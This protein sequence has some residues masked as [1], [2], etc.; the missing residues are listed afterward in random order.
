MMESTLNSVRARLQEATS[1]LPYLP[2]AFRLLWEASRNWSVAWMLLLIVQGVLPGAMVYLARAVVDS[3]VAAL[4]GGAA[5]QEARQTL[6]LAAALGG[7]ML[8]SELIRAALA[9]IRAVQSERVQDFVMGLIHKQCIQADL[10]FY[11]TPAY[12]DHLHRARSEARH[13][14][15]E[16]L[17]SAGSLLQSGITLVAM[18]AILVPYGPW[19]PLALIASALPALYVVLRHSVRQHSWL[20]RTTPDLRRARYYDWLLTAAQTASELRLFSL[21]DHFRAA[22]Q[23]V[24]RRLRREKLYLVKNAGLSQVQAGVV[25]LLL[26]GAAM[27]WMVWRALSGLATL[28][29]LALLYQALAR[30]QGALRSLLE[31]LARAFRNVL[32][33]GDL[34]E[35]LSLESQLDDPPRPV[36]PPR[37]P[38]RAIRFEEVCFRYPGCRRLALDGLNLTIPPGQ[39]A[40]IVGP[41]GAG[42]STLIKLL[43]RLYDPLSGRITLDGLDL[44]AFRKVDLR[45]RLTVLFQEPVHYSATVAENIALGDLALNA[46]VAE[47][48]LASWGAGAEEAIAGLPE[49][50]ETLLGK[51]FSG[52]TDLSVGEWQ[53]IALARAL[54]RQASVFV[55]DEPTSAMDPW[56]EANWMRR[57][58]AFAEGRTAMIITHRLTTA[59]Q[60]DVIHV[61]S[62]GRIVESGP[63]TQLLACGGLYASSWHSQ[64]EADTFAP[65][66]VAV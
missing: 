8:L 17:E 63:H 48:N 61:M 22:Y 16:L 59:R 64:M 66:T 65:S 55:L 41:N 13:R 23:Q 51:W 1:Q 36:A 10:A 19:L 32:F 39:I 30:G 53:R 45:R 6:V 44:R 28:G 33:L 25:G 3:L 21:G 24:R 20:R 15:V 49:G 26:M 18:I 9:W 58:R 62:H 29:D 56:S 46:G 34:F 54:L 31:D 37:M 47:I 12:H 2:R 50:L 60:A 4:G 40:A 27:A 7:L 52:G 57:F 38:S 35:F 42:K 11:E 14:P 43:C 5:S